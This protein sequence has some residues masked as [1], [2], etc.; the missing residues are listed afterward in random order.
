MDSQIWMKQWEAA[1]EPKASVCKHV[2]RCSP[3][4]APYVQQIKTLMTASQPS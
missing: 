1:G 3:G 2:M 4:N